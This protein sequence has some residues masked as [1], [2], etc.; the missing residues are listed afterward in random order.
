MRGGRSVGGVGQ[1]REGDAVAQLVT[2]GLL[3]ASLP[4]R[5]PLQLRGAVSKR[6]GADDGAEGQWWGETG[7]GTPGPGPSHLTGLAVNKPDT[8]PAG[9][10]SERPV[11]RTERIFAWAHSVSTIR[12]LLSHVEDVMQSNLDSGCVCCGCRYRKEGGE[13]WEAAEEAK[14]KPGSDGVYPWD[15]DRRPSTFLCQ[16]RAKVQ[17][18]ERPAI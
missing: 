13:I 4:F 15:L 2:G 14:K 8:N 3:P 9:A 7:R 18:W 17:G 11:A 10:S 5:F 1:A 6:G 12:I 16:A